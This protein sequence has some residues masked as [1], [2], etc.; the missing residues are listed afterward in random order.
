MGEAGAWFSGPKMAWVDGISG[1][2]EGVA[3]R[4]KDFSGQSGKER[5]K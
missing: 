3:D 2:S 1:R 5:T 4:G